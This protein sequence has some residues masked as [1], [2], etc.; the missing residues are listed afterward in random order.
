MM[1]MRIGPCQSPKSAYKAVNQFA[2]WNHSHWSKALIQCK[3]I[4]KS[5]V[6]KSQRGNYLLITEEIWCLDFLS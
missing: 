5:S 2:S 3:L 1:D 6:F 4:P